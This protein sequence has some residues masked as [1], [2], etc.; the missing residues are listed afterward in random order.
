MMLEKMAELR[1]AQAPHI[2]SVGAETF[3]RYPQ[4]LVVDAS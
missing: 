1:G 2:V 4:H 3:P